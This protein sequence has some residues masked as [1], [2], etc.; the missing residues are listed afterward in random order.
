MDTISLFLGNGCCTGHW[1]IARI[2]FMQQQYPP[3]VGEHPFCTPTEAEKQTALSVLMEALPIGRN[4]P[5]GPIDTVEPSGQG[6]APS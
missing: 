1:G 2:D 4:P 5:A 3:A 6:V